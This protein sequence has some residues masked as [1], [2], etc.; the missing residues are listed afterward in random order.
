MIIYKFN[1][2]LNLDVL[3]LGGFMFEVTKVDLKECSLE[4]LLTLSAYEIINT[5]FTDK[6]YINECIETCTWKLSD[7]LSENHD[8][9]S[10]YFYFMDVIKKRKK[11]L[12]KN[13]ENRKY[14]KSIEDKIKDVLLLQKEEKI[15]ENAYQEIMKIL[16]DDE[17][18]YLYIRKLLQ[19][20]KEIYNIKING[21]HII[22]YII[23]KYI[24]NF[25]KMIEDKHSDYINKDYLREI[26]FLFIKDYQVTLKS[27]DRVEIDKKFDEFIEYLKNTLIKNNRKNAAINEVKSMKISKYYNIKPEYLFPEYNLD[28]LSYEV[29]RVITLNQE[30]ANKE[31]MPVEE[32][33]LF[34]D[35]AYKVEGNKILI[36]SMDISPFAVD[37]SILSNYLETLE[38]TKSKMDS[39]V[40]ST[41]NF[42][43]GNTYSAFCYTLEF[44]P[45]GSIK[46]FSLDKGKVYITSWVKTIEDIDD[47]SK[48]IYELYRKVCSKC[49]R[50]VT[51]FD[52]YD[53]NELFNYFLNQEY[54]K[55]IVA[56]KLPFIFSGYTV[57]DEEEIKEY[58]YAL[59]GIIEKL[60]KKEAYDLLEIING[61]VD[62]KHYSIFPISDGVID[63]DITDH[64]N[65][66]S[67]INQRILNE[68]FY[69][70]RKLENHRLEKLYNEYAQKFMK[71]VDELNENNDYVDAESIK[72]NKGRL[73]RKI[74]Y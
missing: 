16:L 18:S 52:L 34:G 40:S 61:K 60:D 67:L 4:E 69:N 3:D 55:F 17:R 62:D 11:R 71:I 39:F 59:S 20:K 36:Y 64:R 26:Y 2:I 72:Q 27:E 50:K 46:S 7:F 23:D 49:N 28:N 14:L 66:L 63:M 29:N 15:E 30:F 57:K 38:F 33:I 41:F 47:N 25:K 48:S 5:D 56:N 9:V 58:L 10:E 43:E 8:L 51:S 24:E 32:A 65:Y 21:K 6:E 44:H 53:V 45:N 35:K 74:R 13:D 37:K 70:S 73:K 1:N 31:K 54:T 19:R 22:F 42:K 12:L 68:L